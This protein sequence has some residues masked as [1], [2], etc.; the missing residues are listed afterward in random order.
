MS[1]DFRFNDYSLSP[2]DLIPDDDELDEPEA[3]VDVQ[4][5]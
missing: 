3:E 2:V 1:S 5:V 4:W